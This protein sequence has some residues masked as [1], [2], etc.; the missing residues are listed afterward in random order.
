MATYSGTLESL[1]ASSIGHWNLRRYSMIEVGGEEIR[2]ALASELMSSYLTLAIGKEVSILLGAKKRVVAIKYENKVKKEKLSSLLGPL[3][4]AFVSTL[5]GLGL[6][7]A[8]G[9]FGAA[10]ALLFGVGFVLGLK[11]VLDVLKFS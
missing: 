3:L 5:F 10:I 7:A 1:G 8:F 6:W 2:D 4:G 9:W 11:Q